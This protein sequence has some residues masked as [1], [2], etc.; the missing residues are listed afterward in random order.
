MTATATTAVTFVSNTQ[1]MI[2]VEACAKH[3]QRLITHL[4]PRQQIEQFIK[5][6][7]AA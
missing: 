7:R 6:Q 2:A 3:L 4:N 5:F 1:M